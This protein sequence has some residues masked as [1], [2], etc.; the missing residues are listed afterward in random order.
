MLSSAC[1]EDTQP[2]ARL[3][4]HFC[5]RT[6][7]SSSG[8]QD[9]QQS[10][11]SSKATNCHPTPIEPEQTKKLVSLSPPSSPLVCSVT[12]KRNR[13][14]IS[15]KLPSICGVVSSIAEMA[16][17]ACLL[18]QHHS[19]VPHSLFFHS[20]VAVLSPDIDLCNCAWCRKWDPFPR[21]HTHAHDLLRGD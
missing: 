10:L 21:I 6:L 3:L 13:L 12:L 19:F 18:S 15:S 7:Q 11:K 14:L 20:D 9:C 8:P 16:E 17:T 1:Q 2:R 4:A 5:T